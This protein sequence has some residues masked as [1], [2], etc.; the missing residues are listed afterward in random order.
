MRGRARR[1]RTGSPAAPAR[2]GRARPRS[3]VRCGREARRRCRSSS[4]PSAVSGLEAG[5]TIAQRLCPSRR[6]GCRETLEPASR[7]IVLHGRFNETFT[8][9]LARVWYSRPTRRAPMVWWPVQRA[10]PA[11]CKHA[12]SPL[13][14]SRSLGSL[15]EGSPSRRS[16]DLAAPAAV[17]GALDS[18]MRTTPYRIASLI[19]GI[20]LLLVALLAV[21]AVAEK[22]LLVITLLGGKQVTLTLDAP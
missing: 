20:A 17:Q 5:R 13:Q 12:G 11:I 18:R 14:T 9:V 1:S 8:V 19:A 2:G 15:P 21:P 4:C 3:A 6:I 7:A 22:R 10:A 16:L